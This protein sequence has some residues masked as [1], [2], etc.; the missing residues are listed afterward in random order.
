[1]HKLTLLKE[2]VVALRT[3][4]KTLSK[5]RRTK[6]RRLQDRKSL[7][8]NESKAL[9]ALKDPVKLEQAEIGESSS[10]IKRRKTGERRCSNCGGIGYNV[11]TCEI[12]FSSDEETESD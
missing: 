2:K 11:R 6:K 7:T 1:M 8:I 3:I 10:R 9:K 4:N 5:R 12:V